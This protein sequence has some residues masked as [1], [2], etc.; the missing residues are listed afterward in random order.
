MKMPANKSII[1]RAISSD[2]GIRVLFCD[3][4]A[5]VRRACEIHHTSKTM[6]AVLGRALTATSLMSSLLKDKDNT[7]TLQLKGDGPAGSIVCVGD[8]MGNVR[9]YADDPTVELPPNKYGK[10]DVGGAVGHGSMYIIKD[11]GMN[12]PY[13]GVSPIVSGEIAEDIT[14]YF[15]SSEQTPTVCA[16]GVRVNTDN[17]CFAAGGYLIQLMPGYEESDVERIETNVNMAESVSKMI[18]DGKNGDEIIALLFDGIEYEMFDEFDIEYRCNCARDR[19]LRALVSLNETDMQELRDA[20][21]PVETNCRFCGKKYVFELDEL[22]KA[23]EE[24]KKQQDEESEDE[25]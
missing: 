15:A 4:T 16:L 23:R 10:L 6:T 17:M 24:A 18:A 13:V 14:E 8:Y 9:G 1:K 12:E 19:Y 20:G 2:G 11:M 22:D 5:I 21:E 25:E 3:S 7:L